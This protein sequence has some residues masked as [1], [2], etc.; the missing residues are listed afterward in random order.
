M[1]WPKP[2]ATLF[3]NNKIFRSILIYV[4]HVDKILLQK[5][6]LQTLWN[7]FFWISSCLFLAAYWE[8]FGEKMA[9]ISL[10]SDMINVNIQTW[11]H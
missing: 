8:S 7:S 2:Q 9:T 10:N 6:V 1:E 5:E 3:E 11:R 4:G